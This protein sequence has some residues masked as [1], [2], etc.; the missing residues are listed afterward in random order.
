MNKAVKSFSIILLLASS[1]KAECLVDY[2]VMYLIANN[3]MHKERDVGYPY[4]ISFNSPKD[5]QL[6]K[7]SIKDLHWLDKR[8]VD[9]KSPSECKK[10]LES[11][12]LLGINNLDLGGYQI[13]QKWY[14][15]SDSSEYFNLKKSY[16]NACNIL[17][18]HFEETGVWNWQTI[19][20]YHSKTPKYNTR[21][22]ERLRTLYQKLQNKGD[23]S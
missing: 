2:S 19:A 20:R 23:K 17:Y 7:E 15:Y 11:I 5:A 16:E 14:N 3:E 18:S 22:A 9:C 8:S 21:Y 1:L 10:N 6:A 4:L 12:N 13:N